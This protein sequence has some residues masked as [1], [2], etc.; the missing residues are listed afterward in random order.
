MKWIALS[1]AATEAAITIEEAQYAYFDAPPN[2]EVRASG[3]DEVDC[4]LYNRR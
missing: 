2:S 4:A 1:L 3:A